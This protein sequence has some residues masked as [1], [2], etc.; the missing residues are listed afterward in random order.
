MSVLGEAC[1]KIF[2]E[3]PYEERE[4]AK[5]NKCRWCPTSKKWCCVDSKNPLIAKYQLRYY[6][7]PFEL[8][9][10]AK[11]AGA[12]W[13]AVERSWYSYQENT[14]LIQVLED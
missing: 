12:K 4:L 1:K 11:L 7:V 5:K 6:D 3:I 2:L 14:A 10:E 13:D 8:K 9:D